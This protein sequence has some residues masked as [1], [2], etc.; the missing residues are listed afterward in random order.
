MA[1]HVDVDE[2]ALQSSSRWQSYGRRDCEGTGD[3]QG[4][5]CEVVPFDCPL[6]AGAGASVFLLRRADAASERGASV[7]YTSSTRL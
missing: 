4:V 1:I 3:T 6:A 2:G 5:Q 7:T